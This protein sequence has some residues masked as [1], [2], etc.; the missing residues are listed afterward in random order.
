MRVRLEHANLCVHDT[1]G[2]VRFLQTAF[3]DFAVR[4]E[5]NDREF[6]Q[7]LSDDPAL[8]HDYELADGRAHEAQPQPGGAG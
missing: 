6:V 5:G 4:P 2:V 7:Y 1:D 8:R 3:P